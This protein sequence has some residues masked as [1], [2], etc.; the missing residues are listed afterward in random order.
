MEWLYS[1]IHLKYRINV[2]GALYY[3]NQCDKIKKL[4]E[5]DIILCNTVKKMKNNS[6]I[7]ENNVWTYS[8]IESISDIKGKY[9][10]V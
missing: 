10:D 5:C 3:Q 7:N 4:K 8:E 9:M 2:S 1:Y 6:K